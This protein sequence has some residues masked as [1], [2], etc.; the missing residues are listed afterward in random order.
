V[1]SR[2]RSLRGAQL[3]RSQN[4]RAEGKTWVEIATEFRSAYGVNARVALR[5]AHGWSQRESADR[6]N[7]RWPTDLKTFKNFSYWELWPSATGY[8]P[9]LE[10]L[11]KLSELYECSIAD[12]LVDAQDYRDRDGIYRGRH[13]LARLPA[14]LSAAGSPETGFGIIATDGDGAAGDVATLVKR[15]Q[16]SDV[17][18][19]AKVTALWA[20]QLDSTVDRRALL[21]KLSFALAL[22]ATM[23][24]DIASAAQTES[25]PAAGMSDLT[26]VWRSRYVYYSSGRNKELDGV[27]YVVVRQESQ[28]LSV[29]SLPHSTGSELNMGLTLDGLT[30][31]GTWEER[32]SPSGYYKG[33][34]YRGAIQLLVAPSGG[35]MTGKWLGF[36]KNFA[37]NTGDWE[38]SLESRSTS[39]QALRRYHLKA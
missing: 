15:L 34:T 13:D 39:R 31:T 7:E 19:L 10:V 11:G 24:A 17:N 20:R 6:W 37:I 21:L 23:P 3:Q 38:L 32:T 30:A 14:A 2:V 9:S 4:L 18:D 1:A 33:A 35:Q 25:R 5:L 29:D 16:E 22:A 28:Q 36:G 26:G 12:L 8:A 27:H